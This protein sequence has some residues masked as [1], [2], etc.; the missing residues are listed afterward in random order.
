MRFMGSP[1][2]GWGVF[3]TV[4]AYI[5]PGWGGAFV[6]RSFLRVSRFS[7]CKVRLMTRSGG[8]ALPRTGPKIRFTQRAAAGF[9]C[10]AGLFLGLGVAGS[11]SLERIDP[12]PPRTRNLGPLPLPADSAGACPL[13]REDLDLPLVRL[14]PAD[15]DSFGMAYSTFNQAL[16]ARVDSLLMAGSFGPPESRDAKK[17]AHLLAR[18]LAVNS[19]H[20]MIGF[21]SD[22][23]KI[24]EASETTLREAFKRYSDPGVYPI[25]RMLRGRMGMGHIC[26]Q[27]DLEADMDSTMN[28]GG[29][30]LR[31]RTE[32]AVLE[33]R[34]QR[35]LVLEVPTILFS[36]VDVILGEHFTCKAEFRHSPGPPAPYDLF[37]FYEIEGMYFRKWGTHKPT[38][39]SFW[40]TPREAS[41]TE[42]P[43]TPLVGSSVYVP[44]VKFELPS[45]LPDLGFDDL[46][47]VD[48][49]Q[50]I[51]SLEYIQ[52]KKYPAWMQRAE[53]RGFKDW[54]SFGPIPPDLRLRFPDL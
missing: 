33:G 27:Y 16:L 19:L 37:L 53:P 31:I 23:E 15:A 12:V 30:S 2:N 41:R 49:P 46:R 10:L 38:A 8:A 44:G 17:T 7:P 5:L 26:V 21:A 34:A 43:R 4:R 3:H 42:L 48:V 13:C 20:Y 18:M 54:S 39:L 35:V 28:V 24:Y 6:N 51:L 9:L 22:P 29:V 11:V 45:F 50:P 40:A 36:T 52:A 32:N 1:G 25:A 14:S 47:L